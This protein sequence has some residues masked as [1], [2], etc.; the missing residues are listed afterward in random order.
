MSWLVLVVV[1]FFCKQR[2]AYEMRIRD[3]SSDVCSSDLPHRRKAALRDG[4]RRAARRL[5]AARGNAREGGRGFGPGLEGRLRHCG[6]LV[7]SEAV[8]F[9]A[10]H[11]T[12]VF[13]TRDERREAARCASSPDVPAEPQGRS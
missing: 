4:A 13:Q 2:T 8:A 7:V 3:W 11:S 9:N 10:R 5:D 6:R 12:A 1:F